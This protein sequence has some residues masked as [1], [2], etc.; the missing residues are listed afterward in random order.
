M[1]Q[2][3]RISIIKI[4]KLNKNVNCRM[5]AIKRPHHF[6]AVASMERS[7]CGELI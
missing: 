7:V 5:A 4:R 6:A 2:V 1:L 3:S